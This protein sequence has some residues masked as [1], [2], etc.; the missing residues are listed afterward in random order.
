MNSPEAAQLDVS[1]FR[2]REATERLNHQEYDLVRE[3]RAGMPWVRRPLS[4][5]SA[6]GGTLYYPESRRR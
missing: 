3:L 5:Q 1:R 2:L 6:T 4:I